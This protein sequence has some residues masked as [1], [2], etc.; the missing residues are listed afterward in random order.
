MLKD[1]GTLGGIITT[2]LKSVGNLSPHYYNKLQKWRQPWQ[3]VPELQP[4]GK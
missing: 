3:E 2:S 4:E 1:V